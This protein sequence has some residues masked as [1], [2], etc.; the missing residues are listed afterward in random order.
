M[1]A[2]GGVNYLII[3]GFTVL[4]TGEVGDLAGMP[5]PDA[6]RG[7]LVD[8]QCVRLNVFKVQEGMFVTIAT[9]NDL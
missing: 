9:G 5:R 7:C 3:T 8:F 4:R 6:G 1:I 2:N